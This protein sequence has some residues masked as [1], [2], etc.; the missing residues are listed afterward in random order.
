MNGQ[1][2]LYEMSLHN[3][4][5]GHYFIEYA[6]RGRKVPSALEL[7]VVD[8]LDRPIS[9]KV[10]RIADGDTTCYQTDQNGCS[11]IKWDSVIS[12]RILNMHIPSVGSGYSSWG[13]SIHFWEM[14]K[15]R[16]PVRITIVLGFQS[17]TVIT[18][19]SKRNLTTQDL[20]VIEKAFSCNDFSN[21]IFKEIDFEEK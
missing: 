19:K 6:K 9:T 5:G 12:P 2:F 7:R 1:Q 10:Y 21:D 16:V 13:K 8:G 4:N 17:N 18:I 14:T 11:Y 3:S 15:K 20:G